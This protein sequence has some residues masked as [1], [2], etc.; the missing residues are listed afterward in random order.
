MTNLG[1]K[2]VVA[3]SWEAVLLEKP[4]LLFLIGCLLTHQASEASSQYG[5]KGCKFYLQQVCSSI[6]LFK[7]L[8]PKPEKAMAPHSSTLAWRVL[9]MEEPHRLQ[10]IGSLRVGSDWTTS[11]SLSCIGEENGNPLQCCCLKNTRDRGAWWAAVYGVAQ[12]RKR[13]KWL[14]SSST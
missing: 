3:A 6:S 1:F 8:V 7:L 4:F 2:G 14:S 5:F 11:L 9:W 13:L 12:S 10:S